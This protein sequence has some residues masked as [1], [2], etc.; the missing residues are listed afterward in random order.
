LKQFAERHGL[1]A[2][3]LHYWV[4]GASKSPVAK[5]SEPVFQEVRLPEVAVTPRA[6]SAEVGLPDGTRVRLVQGTDLDWTM[7][8]V[9]GLRRPCSSP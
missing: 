7:A 2:G 1:S 5:A 6:W 4:Y 8:L 3:R 9:K